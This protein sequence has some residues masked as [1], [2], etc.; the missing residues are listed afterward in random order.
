MRR[1][2]APVPLAI[3]VCEIQALRNSGVHSRRSLLGVPAPA[4]IVVA[5]TYLVGGRMS[6][7]PKGSFAKG[8]FVFAERKSL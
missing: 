5:W 3:S 2:P 7:G 8:F 4:V 6:I 1:C